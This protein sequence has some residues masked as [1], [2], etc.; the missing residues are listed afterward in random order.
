MLVFFTGPYFKEHRL[1]L[2][3][4]LPSHSTTRF[5]F[6]KEAQPPTQTTLRRTLVHAHTFQV[7]RSEMTTQ[8]VAGREALLMYAPRYPRL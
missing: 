7:R 6:F 2:E 5:H 8:T 1:L 3:G 4:S